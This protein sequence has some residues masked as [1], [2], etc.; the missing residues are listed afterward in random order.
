M[1]RRGEILIPGWAECEQTIK[2][3]ADGRGVDC[4][5][6]SRLKVGILSR[7][8]FCQRG[9]I[10]PTSL[11]SKAAILRVMQPLGDSMHLQFR[12][13]WIATFS[14]SRGNRGVSIRTDTAFFMM[15]R[16]SRLGESGLLLKLEDDN[17]TPPKESKCTQTW[18]DNEWPVVLEESCPPAETSF[19]AQSVCQSL[20]R[21]RQ[22]LIEFTRT[23]YFSSVPKRRLKGSGTCAVRSSVF[24]VPL[25]VV[26][27]LVLSQQHQCQILSGKSYS[28]ISWPRPH[29]NLQGKA[30]TVPTYQM[31]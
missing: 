21:R 10:N 3:R 16:A 5:G 6:N 14:L 8:N 7:A 15:H 4:G 24:Y 18:G 17:V 19:I 29:F 27:K 25:I 28:G 23:V 1:N 9:C 13:C 22:L 12:T 31:A 11:M 26:K 20:R 2:Q 30:L